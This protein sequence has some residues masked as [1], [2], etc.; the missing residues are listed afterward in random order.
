MLFSDQHDVS[1]GKILLLM[2]NHQ[3]LRDSMVLQTSS[4]QRHLQKNVPFRGGLL[5]P[6]YWCS[7]KGDILIFI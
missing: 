6:L 3:E 4:K 1:A 7:I 5:T 2:I